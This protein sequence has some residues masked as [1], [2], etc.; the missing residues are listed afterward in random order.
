M[1]EIGQRFIPYKMFNGIH[2]PNCLL[3][4]KE[5]SSN[6]KLCWGRLS[7]YAGEDGFCVP[8][9]EL[10]SKELGI[11]LSTVRNVLNEL[12]EFKLIEIE[13]PKG[14]DRLFHKNCRYYFLWHEILTPRTDKNNTSGLVNST[15]LYNKRLINN[16]I[17]ISSKEDSI[18]SKETISP[19]L[20]NRRNRFL[21]DNKNNIAKNKYSEK[22]LRFLDYWEKVGLKESSYDKA[23]K[24]WDRS[25]LFIDKLL[26]GT[27]FNQTEYE[28]Y[29]NYKFSTKEI[30]TAIDRFALVALHPDYEPRNLE[31]KQ[32]LSKYYLFN[33]IFNERG[34]ENKGY[35]RSCFIKFLENEPKLVKEKDIIVEDKYPIVTKAIKKKYAQTIMGMDDFTFTN[36]DENDFRKA[37]IFAQEFLQKNK[38]RLIGSYQEL[39]PYK[40]AECLLSALMKTSP[41]IVKV[42]PY[43]LY[44]SVMQKQLPAYLYSTAIMK[45]ENSSSSNENNFYNFGQPLE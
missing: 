1:I 15:G 12:K 19:A 39:K 36:Q 11:S 24:S 5:L 25:L 10:L 44:N 13:S 34:N 20:I 28:K 29:Y 9:Q 41:A 21:S 22:T 35:G 31:F 16:K 7:Q 32:K 26:K 27:M 37:A 38:S 17:N 8:K 6:A 18:V 4:M 30:K 45:E 2:I 42:K 33:F 3:E 14:E 43:W 23:I 40:V